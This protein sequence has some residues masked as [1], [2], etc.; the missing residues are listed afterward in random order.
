MT[1][2]MQKKLYLHIIPYSHTHTLRDHSYT[3][4]IHITSCNTPKYLK[5]MGQTM[6]IPCTSSVAVASTESSLFSARH[7]YVPWSCSIT[8][9]IC[10]LPV[11]TLWNRLPSSLQHDNSMKLQHYFTEVWDKQ[12]YFS[13]SHGNWGGKARCAAR[14]NACT[15][16]NSQVLE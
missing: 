3:I 15:H 11:P 16:H 12:K 2:N 14:T 4:K 8:S 9:L 13:V 6:C 10:R 5:S 1:R 7:W